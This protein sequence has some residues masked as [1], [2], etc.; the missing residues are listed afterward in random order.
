MKTASVRQVRR[1][2]YKTSKKRWMHY[3]AHLSPLIRGTNG[4]IFPNPVTDMITL[5]V[6]GLLQKG[7]ALFRQGDLDGAEGCFKKMLHHN[8]AHAAAA[9]MTGLVYCRKGHLA[10]GESLMAGATKKAPWHGEW[11]QNLARAREALGQVG[12]KEKINP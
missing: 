8:P 4:P 2:I 11:R 12:I 3:K 7:V 9:Y 5:P 1:P 6:P 10:Q